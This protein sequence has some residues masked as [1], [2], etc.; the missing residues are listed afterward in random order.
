MKGWQEII[1]KRACTDR[2]GMLNRPY[3]YLAI[4]YDMRR[5][6]LGRGH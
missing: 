6:G 2:K 3:S 1:K 4:V 5:V